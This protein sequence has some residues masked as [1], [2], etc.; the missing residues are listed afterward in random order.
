MSTEEIKYQAAKE[1]LEQI[2]SDLES[3]EV[4][5]D[6]LSDKIKRATKLFTICKAKLVKTEEEVDKILKDLFPKE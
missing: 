1:E 3:N 6:E 4:N 5:V 2:L